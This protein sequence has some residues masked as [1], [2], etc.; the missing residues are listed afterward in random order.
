[1]DAGSAAARVEQFFEPEQVEILR[2]RFRAVEIAVQIGPDSLIG[3][4]PELSGIGVEMPEQGFV[5]PVALVRRRPER[6]LDY[7]VDRHERNLR[8]VWGAADLVVR[9]DALGRQDHP[10]CRQRQI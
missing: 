8:L 5:E 7:G 4:S 6:R 9:Y 1:M 10:V 3:I 2:P